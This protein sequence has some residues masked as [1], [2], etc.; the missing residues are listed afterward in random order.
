[1]SSDGEHMKSGTYPNPMLMQV[2]KRPIK[3]IQLRRI[4]GEN[5]VQT[6]PDMQIA[7]NKIAQ[8]PYSS[9]L[10]DVLAPFFNRATIFDVEGKVVSRDEFRAYLR[11]INRREA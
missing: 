4:E 1:M 11:A 5:F 6:V 10:M 3:R 2:L 9:S 8:I 7:G